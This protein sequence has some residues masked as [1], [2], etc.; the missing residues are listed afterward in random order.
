[1]PK[2]A[3]VEAAYFLIFLAL[4]MLFPLMMNAL[5]KLSPTV[6]GTISSLANSSMY[7]GTTLGSLTAGLLYSCSGAFMSVSLLAAVCF[8][9][10]L[11]L[12]SGSGAFSAVSPVL[13]HKKQTLKQ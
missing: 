5:Q 6:R 12:F 8:C 3:L 7:F 9:L 13:S 2:L 11:G 4:S 10:S 1:M